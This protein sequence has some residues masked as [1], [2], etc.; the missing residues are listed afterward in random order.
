MQG[1]ELLYKTFLHH[2]LPIIVVYEEEIEN[3]FNNFRYIIKFLVKLT[4]LPHPLSKTSPSCSDAIQ[5][6]VLQR[7]P[8]LGGD[9][10]DEDDEKDPAIGM[11][12]GSFR[13]NITSCYL[14]SKIIGFVYLLFSC[15]AVPGPDL[16][17]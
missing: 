2:E 17:L 10:D 14:N 6:F 7:C 3:S 12:K 1:N 5:Q 4:Q 15:L 9:P 13:Y 11:Y 8:K 16:I